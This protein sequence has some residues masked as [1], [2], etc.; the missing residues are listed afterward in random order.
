MAIGMMTSG[1][2]PRSGAA[3]DDE[4]EEEDFANHRLTFAAI[5]M[6]L[7]AAIGGFL[8]GYDTG[9]VSGAMVYIRDDFGLDDIWQEVIISITIL[10]AWIFS[11]IAGTIS[12]KFGRKRTVILS[13]VIFTIGSL[14]MGLAPNVWLL[15]A[16]RF[17]V[18]AGVGLAS[19]IV[20]L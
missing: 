20:P 13:S 6:V 2:K 12:D 17:V 4:N 14:M 7:M 19:M 3:D 9:I 10:S 5:K 8:F 11:I 15:L 16:G 18:G 1:S